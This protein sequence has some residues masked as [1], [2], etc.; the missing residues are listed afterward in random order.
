MLQ[1]VKINHLLET[2]GSGSF[3]SCL[4][5]DSVVVDLKEEDRHLIPKIQRLMGSTKFGNF[6]INTS[7]GKS[8]GRLRKQ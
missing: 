5:H 1:A 7:V 4:I 2:Q 6:S 3:L 8:L